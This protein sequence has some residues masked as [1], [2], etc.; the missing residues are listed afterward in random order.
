MRFVHKLM[1]MLQNPGVTSRIVDSWNHLMGIYS[2]GG[3]SEEYNF[4]IASVDRKTTRKQQEKN[5]QLISNR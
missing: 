4:V 3:W 1:G 5:K 2:G